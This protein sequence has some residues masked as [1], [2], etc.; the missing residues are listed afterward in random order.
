M[1]TWNGKN[2]GEKGKEEESKKE[3]GRKKP[4]TF[5]FFHVSSVNQVTWHPVLRHP[6]LAL[7]PSL[8]VVIPFDP[9]FSISLLFRSMNSYILLFLIISMSY[10]PILQGTDEP[11]FLPESLSWLI[12]INEVLLCFPLQLTWPITGAFD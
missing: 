2:E 8:F 12:G 5:L 4:Y 9:E 6:S 10:F 7:S 1:E 11:V 3:E